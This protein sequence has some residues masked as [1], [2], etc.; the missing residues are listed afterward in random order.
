MPCGIHCLLMVRENCS[1]C[2]R[3]RRVLLGTRA[4]R[5]YSPPKISAISTH[6][7]LFLSDTPFAIRINRPRIVEVNYE[8]QTEVADKTR[9]EY[10]R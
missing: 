1:W 9:G 8:K 6:A 10:G 2:A 5:K 4:L 7:Q 3:I